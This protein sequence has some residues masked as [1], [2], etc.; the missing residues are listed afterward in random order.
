MTDID[1]KN[2]LDLMIFDLDGT[3]ID[4][5]RQIEFAMNKARA[6][7]GFTESPKG[8]IFE[9]LGLPVNELFNDLILSHVGQKELIAEFRINLFE[10]IT[11]GNKCFPDVVPLIN[12]IQQLGIKV[13]IATGKSTNMAKRVIE[14]SELRE[15]IDFIQGTD[16]FL[17][18]P[19]PEVINRCLQ[20]F[21]GSRAVMIG[22][23]AED[24]IAATAAGIPCIGIAQ[25]AHSEV[26]LH[27]GGAF[28]T[29]KD[30][31]GFYGWF[32]N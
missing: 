5:H 23:R 3:L 21:P 10:S 7:L 31:C 20:K 15:S 12:K 9:K 27:N 32:T 18:K 2:S 25:S 24:M 4:S 22:D 26:T 29:F 16:G 19:N 1:F 13:A 14:N 28:L 30:V 6:T 17:P 8:Q 11:L